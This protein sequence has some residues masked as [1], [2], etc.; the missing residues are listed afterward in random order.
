MSS[1]RRSPP[2]ATAPAPAR[3]IARRLGSAAR[4]AKD[5]RSRSDAEPVLFSDPDYEALIDYLVDEAVRAWRKQNS[6]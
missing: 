6:P 3:P 5:K 1:R 4:S 2:V